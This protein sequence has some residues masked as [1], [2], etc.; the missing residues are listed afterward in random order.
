LC[1][2]VLWHLWPSRLLPTLRVIQHDKTY[3]IYDGIKN[4][5]EIKQ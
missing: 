4:H 5:M 3:E 1:L 2:L